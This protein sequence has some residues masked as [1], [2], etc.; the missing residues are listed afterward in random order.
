V[1]APAPVAR[2]PGDGGTT[3]LSKREREV[4]ELVA[5]GNSNPQ[6]AQTLY[7]SP[8][9]VEGHMSRIFGK[10]GVSSRAELAARV[11]LASAG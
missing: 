8:K 9:T 11:A 2:R 6:I 4:A 5:A 1:S 7:L 3:E 10:L